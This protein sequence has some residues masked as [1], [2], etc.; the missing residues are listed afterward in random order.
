[1]MKLLAASAFA[2]SLTTMTFAV[3]A[4]D[5]SIEDMFT[6]HAAAADEAGVANSLMRCSGLLAAM[7]VE[8][9]SLNQDLFEKTLLG[10]GAIQKA[11][12]NL[13][14]SNGREYDQTTIT[15][16]TV[17]W[18]QHYQRRFNSNLIETGEKFGSDDQIKGDL[19]FCVAISQPRLGS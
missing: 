3:E 2:A 14:A 12:A 17:D 7:S 18:A 9:Q 11:A 4:S 6:K 10:A 19:N 1:M 15:G 13:Y 8:F 16:W 5:I